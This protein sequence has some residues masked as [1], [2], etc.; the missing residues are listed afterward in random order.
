MISYEGNDF[1]PILNIDKYYISKNGEVLSTMKKNYRILKT[2]ISN[3]TGYELVV[4]YK[5]KKSITKTIHRLMAMT[6]LEYYNEKLYVDH[7]DN[8][9]TNNNLENLRMVTPSQNNK[10]LLSANGV[11]RDFDKR[12]NTRLSWR[13]Y[14]WD[15]NNKKCTAS[16]ACKI[17][18]ELF[19]YI[20][21]TNVREEMVKKYY[22][23]V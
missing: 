12:R 21:A 13:A 14:W 3:S 19:A 17:Y 8:V 6:F 11:Y 16:F 5:N 2:T 18:G 20:L 10:N 23:R 1:Y 22:N 4:L 7:K 9:K 15:D